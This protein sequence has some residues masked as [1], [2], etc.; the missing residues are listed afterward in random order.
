[1]HG[2][3]VRVSVVRHD[4]YVSCVTFATSQKF[5]RRL[6][7][8]R[9]QPLRR[10]VACRAA[11]MEEATPADMQLRPNYRQRCGSTLRSRIRWTSPSFSARSP[12]MPGNYPREPVSRRRTARAAV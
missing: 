10:A 4:T 3:R 1:V 5:F 11:T 2:S 12:L 9:F 7:V 8:V 6:C